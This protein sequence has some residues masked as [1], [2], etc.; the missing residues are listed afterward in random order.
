VSNPGKKK[1]KEMLDRLRY[2]RLVDDTALNADAQQKLADDPELKQELLLNKALRLGKTEAPEMP[3]SMVDDALRRADELKSGSQTRPHTARFSWQL[4]AAVAMGAVVIAV[5][6]LFQLP[7]KLTRTDDGGLEVGVE[8]AWATGNGY[9]LDYTIEF[10][11]PYT[12]TSQDSPDHPLWRIEQL[13]ADWSAEHPES[14]TPDVRP[15]ASLEIASGNLNYGGE[16]LYQYSL[17]IKVFSADEDEIEGLVEL[18]AGVAE[19][20]EPEVDAEHWYFNEQIP[21]TYFTGRT[22]TINGQGYNYPQEIDLKSLEMLEMLLHFS[23]EQGQLYYALDDIEEYRRYGLG[24]VVKV[25]WPDDE[26]VQFE[27]VAVKLEFSTLGLPSWFHY[28]SVY[29]PEAEVDVDF[30]ISKLLHTHARGLAKAYEKHGGQSS[31][32]SDTVIVPLIPDSVWLNS[33]PGELLAATSFEEIQARIEEAR[34]L[35]KLIERVRQEY[36]GTARYLSTQLVEFD[37]VP[38]HWVGRLRLDYN[39]RILYRLV[40]DIREAGYDDYKTLVGLPWSIRERQVAQRNKDELKAYRAVAIWMFLPQVRWTAI[41]REDRA[42]G[43]LEEFTPA[44]LESARLQGDVVTEVFNDWVA[45]NPELGEKFGGSPAPTEMSAKARLI[46]ND[47]GDVL[48]SVYVGVE[49]LDRDTA[50]AWIDELIAL[51]EA[52]GKVTTKP[53]TRMEQTIYFPPEE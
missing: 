43:L 22:V 5:V 51:V 23:G 25:W 39:D 53:S 17:Y 27:N 11:E 2:G 14:G 36:P 15:A 30:D 4:A 40:E 12:G 37:G 35:D 8:S 38:T 49:D 21:D 50:Q 1:D 10:D 29:I 16:T 31:I 18:L 33:A 44:E 19:L 32:Y 20:S 9:V 45:D 41:P 28:M 42:K 48:M 26:T 46:H 34:E 52:T 6:V 13:L 24:D 3:P 47:A 7:L